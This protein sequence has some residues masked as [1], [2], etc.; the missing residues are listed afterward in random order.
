[1]FLVNDIS[2]P[3]VAFISNDIRDENVYDKSTVD[4]ILQLILSN[5]GR[6]MLFDY[7]VYL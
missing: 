1:M 6:K 5:L 4:L 2:A 7:K 3:S